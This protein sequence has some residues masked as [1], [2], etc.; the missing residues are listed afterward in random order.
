MDAAAL[1]GVYQAFQKF[2]AYFAP[3]FG[4]KQW[5]AQ[6]GRCLRVLLVQSEVRRRRMQRFLSEGRWDDDRVIGRLQEYLG[7]RLEDP[8]GVWVLDGSEFLQLG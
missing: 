3:A 5:R 1:E 2:H 6:S 4:R 7:F 8:Q